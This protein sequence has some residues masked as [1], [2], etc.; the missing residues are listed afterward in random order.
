MRHGV[1]P[2]R[3]A[4]LEYLKIKN[5]YQCHFM[6]TKVIKGTDADDSTSKILNGHNFIGLVERLDEGL[7]FCVRS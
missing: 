7:V 4:I 1:N 6:L 5:N 2:N 3:P